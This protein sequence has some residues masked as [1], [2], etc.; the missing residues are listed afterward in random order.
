MHPALFSHFNSSGTFFI[1][2]LNSTFFSCIFVSRKLS[3]FSFAK[4]RDLCSLGGFSSSAVVCHSPQLTTFFCKPFSIT[5]SF[6][7]YC[8]TSHVF[9]H[10]FLR[11]Y[12]NSNQR[13]LLRFNSLTLYPLPLNF[14]IKLQFLLQMQSL[15]Y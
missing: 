5:S 15:T 4:P 11:L 2:L 3:M 12:P 10:R 9:L 13:S 6:S 8:F 1:S 7:L 14:L